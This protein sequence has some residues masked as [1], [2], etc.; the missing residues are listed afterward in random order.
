[1]SEMP[2]AFLFCLLLGLFDASARGRR[3]REQAARVVEE[4][5]ILLAVRSRVHAS[6]VAHVLV[7]PLLDVLQPLLQHLVQ[8]FSATTT[9]YI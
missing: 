7:L 2:R 8:L 9:K 6:K 1:M 5:V 4:L 3:L